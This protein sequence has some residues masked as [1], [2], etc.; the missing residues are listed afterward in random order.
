MATGKRRPTISR[1]ERACT[2]ISRQRPDDGDH[3]P[4]IGSQGS[5]KLILQFQF[6]VIH[7][8][9][10]LTHLLVGGAAFGK[11][12]AVRGWVTLNATSIARAFTGAW[13]IIKAAIFPALVR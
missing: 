7:A 6:H 2:F 3:L 10:E 1:Q 9:N 12:S 8:R 13:N 5:G 4:D 11:S